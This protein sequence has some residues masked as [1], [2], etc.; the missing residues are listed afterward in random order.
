VRRREVPPPP[1]TATPPPPSPP[2]AQKV[3]LRQHVTR[4]TREA[5]A[6]QGREAAGD[7]AKLKAVIIALSRL[8]A[9]ATL[10]G[11]EAAVADLEE[12]FRSISSRSK[13]E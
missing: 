6:L 13:A 1:P 5:R 3:D 11:Q 9:Q 12:E 8:A 7:Q 4:L 2:P 10:D